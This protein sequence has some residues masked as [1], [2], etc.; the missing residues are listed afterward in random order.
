VG[1]HD[2]EGSTEN[3]IV[4]RPAERFD[5]ATV[6]LDPFDP[7]PEGR[8]KMVLQD[9]GRLKHIRFQSPDGLHWEELGP[10]AALENA[11][12]R[13]SLCVDPLTGQWRIYFKRSGPRTV[14]LAVSDNFTHWTDCGEVLAP[15]ESDPPDTE[16]YGMVAF[17]DGSWRLGML[18]T[19]KVLERRLNAQLVRLD[20]QGRPTRYRPGQVFLDH[21]AWGQWDSAWAF[22]GNCGPIR[23]GEELRFYYQGRPTLHWS[24]PPNGTGHF[25]AIGLAR[26]R[27]DG[28]VSLDGTGTLTTNPIPVTGRFLC[29]N[30]NAANGEIR[31]ELLDED[32]SPLPGM[33]AAD[34]FPLTCDATYFKQAWGRKSNLSDLVDRRVRIRATLRN[35]SLYSMWFC[36]K[37][38]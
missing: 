21:G 5:S 16:F 20:E 12:D 36:N 2:F 26:L 35:A 24:D 32:G 4:Y 31:L 9:K 8:F 1:L 30:G 15:T 33:T 17:V 22:S 18:E 28:Y 34:H 27:A 19:F 6:I 14:H 13:H 29:I 7:P 3:N 38:G 37:P 11:G 23:V 10:I 25:G